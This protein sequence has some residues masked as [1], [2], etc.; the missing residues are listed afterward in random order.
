MEIKWTINEDNLIEM[1]LTGQLVFK[2]Y[3]EF[4]DK[5]EPTVKKA[6]EVRLLAI[7]HDFTG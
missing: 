7:L 5:L 4:Q 1:H 3:R 2:E 6:G